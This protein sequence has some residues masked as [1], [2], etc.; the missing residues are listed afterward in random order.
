MNIKKQIAILLSGLLLLMVSCKKSSDGYEPLGGSQSAIG[1]VGNSFSIGTISGVASVS[2]NVTNLSNGESTVAYT[3]NITNSSYLD[4]IKSMDDVSVTG[5]S[6]QRESTYR[7]TT[8]G[9]ESIYPEGNLT[10]VKYDA[11]VGDVY[12]LKRGSKTIR[13]EVTLVSSDDD[14]YW[15]GMYIKTIKVK[16]TGRG[17]PGVTNIEFVFNHRFGIVGIKVLFEDGTSKEIG[18]V[19]GNYN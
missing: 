7:I 8:E 12:S 15:A 18:I 14:Y 2:A 4:M 10:L 5:S 9:I 1:E 19:S 13:R 17:I 6:V 16:E 11:K 3:A